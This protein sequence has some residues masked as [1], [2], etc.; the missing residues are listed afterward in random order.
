[1]FCDWL[2][3]VIGTRRIRQ[4]EVEVEMVGGPAGQVG[5]GSGPVGARRVSSAMPGI[6]MILVQ[7]G[8]PSHVSDSE[9][10]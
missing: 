8:E 9:K 4:L 3:K 1:M 2:R 10:G 5:C 7:S 6:A